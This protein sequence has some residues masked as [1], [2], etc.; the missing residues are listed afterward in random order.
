MNA[1][2]GTR[3]YGPGSPWGTRVVGADVQHTRFPVD[4]A[5][6]HTSERAHCLE[7]EWTE[8]EAP[9]AAATGHASTYGH[10]AMVCKIELF[11][12]RRAPTED[13]K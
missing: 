5:L 11:M 6:T 12:Y 4:C 1:D 3:K 13:V 8:D 7:C 2:Y 10:R 9:H